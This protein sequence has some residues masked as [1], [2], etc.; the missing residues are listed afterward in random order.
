VDRNNKKIS[1]SIRAFQDGMDRKDLES[2][3][4]P[5]SEPPEETTTAFGEAL[6]AKLNTNGD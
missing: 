1:L 5:N 2:Y 3:L 4:S 6:R